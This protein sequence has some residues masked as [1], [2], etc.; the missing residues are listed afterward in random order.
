[1]F[2]FSLSLSN[3]SFFWYEWV[4]FVRVWV[5][6]YRKI[7]LQKMSKILLTVSPVPETTKIYYR[8]FNKSVFYKLYPWTLAVPMRLCFWYHIDKM[9]VARLYWYTVTVLMLSP[10][11]HDP[12]IRCIRRLLSTDCEVENMFS[13]LCMFSILLRQL[14]V[15][16]GWAPLQITGNLSRSPVLDHFRVLLSSA[17]TI[18]PL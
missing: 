16:S 13:Y 5:V 12:F 2:F 4:S 15:W 11:H 10:R 14:K 7:T 8:H 6:A 1:M 3:K 18:E 9:P 17:A